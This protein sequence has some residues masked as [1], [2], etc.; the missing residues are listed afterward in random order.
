MYEINEKRLFAITVTECT[1]FKSLRSWP[2]EIIL[3]HFPRAPFINGIPRVFLLNEEQ[4][5]S[6]EVCASNL[7]IQT[8][9]QLSQHTHNP[10]HKFYYLTVPI[11]FCQE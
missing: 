4:S 3:Q 9:K 5:L 10:R 6:V 11:K 1:E 7:R 2:Y 8:H